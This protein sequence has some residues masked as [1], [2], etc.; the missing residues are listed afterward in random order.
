[1]LAPA[2]TPRAV[3]DKLNRAITDALRLPDIGARMRALGA[4]PAP[5]T[6]QAF[7]TKIKNELRAMADVARSAGL[8]PE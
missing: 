4:E 1:M 3:I 5:S 7:E 2:K 6:P 8:K